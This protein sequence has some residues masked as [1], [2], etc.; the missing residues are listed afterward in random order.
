MDLRRKV[1]I[2]YVPIE[3]T[4]LP[5]VGKNFM[6]INCFWVSGQFKGHGNGKRLLQQCKD[7]A[8]EVDGIVAMPSDKKRPFM[9]DPKFLK[10]Q[11]FEII[12][13]A[14]KPPPAP[15]RMASLLIIP[16]RVRSPIY[17]SNMACVPM[18]RKKV[19]P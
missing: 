13:E 6:V 10:K 1:F 8:K 14:P 7:D 18:L 5:L 19:Y 17:T 15:T 12:N 9:S 4:W 3:Q 2:E 11:G 16:A